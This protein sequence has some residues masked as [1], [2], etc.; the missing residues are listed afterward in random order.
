M[1]VVR[2]SMQPTVAKDL[3]MQFLR[4][5]IDDESGATAIEYALIASL[6]S[7]VIIAGATLIGTNLDVTFDTLGT[8]LAP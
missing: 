7:I 4:N 1:Q 8:A 5:L 3:L 6:I 2:V